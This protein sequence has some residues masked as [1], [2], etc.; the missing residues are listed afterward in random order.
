M[1]PEFT[2]PETY[3]CLIVFI[4]TAFD[5]PKQHNRL[6]DYTKSEES[7]DLIDLSKK[8]SEKEGKDRE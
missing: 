4:C 1:F 5:P 2:N 6:N 7:Q 8:G 3:G